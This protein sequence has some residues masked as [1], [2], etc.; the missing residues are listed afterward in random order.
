MSTFTAAPIGYAR[1]RIGCEVPKL[2]A[3]DQGEVMRSSTGETEHLA[4][5]YTNDCGAAFSDYERALLAIQRGERVDMRRVPIGTRDVGS[6]M[7]FQTTV[8]GYKVSDWTPCWPMDSVKHFH[9]TVPQWNCQWCKMPPR[10]PENSSVLAKARYNMYAA[11]HVYHYAMQMIKNNFIEFP[12]LSPAREWFDLQ[13]E[14]NSMYKDKKY[15]IDMPPE[16]KQAAADAL[17]IEI[18]LE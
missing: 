9:D 18:E 3:N 14:M 17:N 13:L 8:N 6:F 2:I 11:Y 16:V 10:L 5:Y 12:E 15:V 7:A 4:G 1:S